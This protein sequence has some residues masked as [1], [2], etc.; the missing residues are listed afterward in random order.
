VP[1]A[2]E[3][4]TFQAPNVPG[5]KHFGIMIAGAAA[6]NVLTLNSLK[7]DV[8]DSH[9]KFRPPVLGS[10]PF[11]VTGKQQCLMSCIH[12]YKAA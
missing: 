5:N 7:M 11:T 12:L 3:G 2:A 1:P 6:A 4:L 8:D 10:Y 9:Y